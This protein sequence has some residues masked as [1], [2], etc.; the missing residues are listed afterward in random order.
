MTE[1][2]AEALTP[3]QATELVQI[4][5]LQARWENHCSDPDSRP[6]TIGD[7]RARQR[8]HEQFQA[9][10]NDYTKKHRTTSFPETTQ[11]VPDRLAIWC[12]TLRAVFRGA[13]GGN[14]VQVM[15]KVY[16]LAD[17]IAARMEAGPVSRGSGEDLAAAACE[18]DV[19]IAWCA[20]L[21]APVKA[22]AV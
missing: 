3:E 15:A 6:D 12:R 7:L 4:L 9:A 21:S 10:W 8:A 16:R 5:D 14:P 22:E 11:S 17:R 1:R 2:A 19:V 20:T 13:T 18:L